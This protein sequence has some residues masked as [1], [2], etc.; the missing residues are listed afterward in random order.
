M[1]VKS[2]EMQDQLRIYTIKP[3]EMG[4][5]IDEW[6]QLIAALRQKH[7]FDMLGAWTIE[8]ENR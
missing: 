3:G 7:G 5:W 1:E 8:S 6:R 4:Q 2:Q